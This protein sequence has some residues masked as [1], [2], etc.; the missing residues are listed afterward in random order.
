MMFA[1][2]NGSSWQVE[3]VE[4]PDDPNLRRCGANASV[5]WNAV[6][7]EFWTAHN[8]QPSDWRLPS[9]VEV[10]SSSSPGNW[11][12]ERAPEET[13]LVLQPVT[14]AS[15]GTAYFSSSSQLHTTSG[16]GELMLRL[17]R[18]D[19]L[20]PGSTWVPEIVDW[21]VGIYP[22]GP[23]IDPPTGLPAFAYYSVLRPVPALRF[24][25]RLP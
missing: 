18:R 17:W 19:T 25:R 7:G 13:A 9:Q 14:I 24:V 23:A 4:T 1:L 11:A 10:C 3:T 20:D 2:W 6:R 21:T 15:D 16:F 5:A 8:C 12:C 22:S